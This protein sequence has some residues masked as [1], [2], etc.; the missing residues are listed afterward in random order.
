MAPWNFDDGSAAYV[1]VRWQPLGW[2]GAWVVAALLVTG[3]ASGPHV[4]KFEEGVAFEKAG[5]PDEALRAY[6]AALE[7]APGLVEARQ[8]VGTIYYEQKKYDKAEREF[9]LILSQDGERVAARENLAVALEAKGGQEEEALQHWQ[10]ALAKEERPEWKNYGRASVTRLEKKI[11]AEALAPP[12]DVDR[13]PAFAAKARPNDVA[14]VIGIERYQKLPLA[15][16]AKADAETVA[17]YLRALGYPARNVEVLFNDQA[18]LTGIKVA[19][20]SWLPSRVQSDSRVLV[21]YAGHGSP[22]PVT[23]E[24]YLVPHDGDPALLKDTAYPL[25]TLYA[26]LADLKAGQVVVTLDSCFSGQGGAR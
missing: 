8:N 24:A 9:R 21:Y 12:S 7:T 13:I 26:K 23:G 3:C 19:L 16:H 22:D 15:R 20:E 17:K 14:V 10:T 18:T 2:L 1:H 25:K 4:A 5:K 11:Q 6:Y